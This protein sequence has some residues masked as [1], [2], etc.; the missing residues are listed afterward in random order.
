MA[1]RCYPLD[2]WELNNHLAFNLLKEGIMVYNSGKVNSCLNKN[3]YANIN[4][5][6]FLY[7]RGTK[8]FFSEIW[9]INGLF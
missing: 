9:N 5:G 8:E 6:L 3:G 2:L 4:P 1:S 7:A